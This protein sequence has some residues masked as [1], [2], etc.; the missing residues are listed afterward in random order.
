VATLAV[1]KPFLPLWPAVL[2]FGATL[3]VLCATARRTGRAL[4]R[5]T[6]RSWTVAAVAVGLALWTAMMWSI[7]T[8]RAGNPELVHGRFAANLHGSVTPLSEGRFH[9]LQLAEARLFTSAASLFYLAGVL[10]DAR[11][12]RRKG[13]S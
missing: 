13:R 2:L 12:L 7:W 1:A 6:P 8:L 10:F 4:P 9:D 11:A 3:P 5:G